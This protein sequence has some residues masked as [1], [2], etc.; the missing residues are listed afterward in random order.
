MGTIFHHV[1][2]IYEKVEEKK[3][4]NNKIFLLSEVYCNLNWLGCGAFGSV[5][6]TFIF[7][8]HKLEYN[9]AAAT[10]YP[11]P[12]SSYMYIRRE[13][14]RERQQLYSL[15]YVRYKVGSSSFGRGACT[16]IRLG[17]GK[18]GPRRRRNTT[19]QHFVPKRERARARQ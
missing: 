5:T 13:R 19:F 17:V 7:T 2:S 11:G 10:S 14:E 9:A 12:Y 16:L 8:I 6:K 18:L 1:G 15:R 3:K 4:K